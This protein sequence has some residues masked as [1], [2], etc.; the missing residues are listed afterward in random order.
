MIIKLL[1]LIPPNTK[2]DFFGHRFY[3]MLAS[4]IILGGS[5]LM[6]TTKGLNFG[7]DFVGG[8]I[9]EIKTE[10]APD[11]P[12]LRE[13]LKELHLGDISIQEFGAADNLMI[14]MPQQEVQP[15]AAEAD[16]QRGAIEK[17]QAALN[18]EFDNKVDY[19][20]TEF[21]GPQVGK[22]LKRAGIF[23][24]LIAMGGIMA[25]I[26]FRFN[27]QYGVGAMLALLHDVVGILGLF[28]LT[29][30]HFDLSTLA[31]ILLVAGYSINETVIIFDRVR[32]TLRKYK[33]MPMTEII[34]FS[35]NSTLPR[36]LM[37]SG[38]TLLALLALYMFGGEV[39]RSFVSALFFGILIG[40]HS[41]YFVSTPSLYYLKLRPDPEKPGT[42]VAE[43]PA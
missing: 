36:T 28:S 15:G 4:I 14:R 7:I 9:I 21:V 8:T 31:A 10:T 11:L 13:V 22:E 20:R 37:T 6:L 18:K 40:T 38:S 32:E 39:I 41:S 1:E 3:A 30:M 33:K 29:Q 24:V 23:A 25:Y 2:I 19:R 42:A 5:T 17:V 27:W 34:N 43:E 16:V 26:W 12:H 35:I